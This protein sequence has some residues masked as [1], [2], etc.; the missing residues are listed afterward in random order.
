M[1]VE[2]TSSEHPRTKGAKKIEVMIQIYCKANHGTQGELCPECSEFKEYA[3]MRLDKCPF[4]DKK[5]L[6]ANALFIATDRI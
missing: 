1:A 5:T 3:F 6:A 4:K 2:E